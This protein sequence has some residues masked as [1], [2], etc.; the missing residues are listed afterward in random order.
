M[1]LLVGEDLFGFGELLKVVAALARLERLELDAVKHPQVALQ[2]TLVLADILRA[3]LR[4]YG[5]SNATT[6][7][8]EPSACRIWHGK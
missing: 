6:V 1:L 5:A 3:P 8:P 4:V 2:Y 7:R